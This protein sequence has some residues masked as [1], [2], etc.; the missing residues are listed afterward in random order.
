[1]FKTYENLFK[2]P[3]RHYKSP[4]ERGD[5][6]E[7]DTSPELN[8]EGIKQYQSLIGC[9]QWAISLGRF[10]IMVAVMTMS[11]FRVAP[12]KGHLERAKRI[13]GYLHRM[14]HSSIIFMTEEPDF[15]DLQ[16]LLPSWA[17]SVYGDVRERIPHDIPAPKGKAIWT[18]T[19]ADANLAHCFA[20]GR[21][22]MGVLHFLNKT[23][24]DWFSKKQSTVETSTYGSEFVAART[25]TEQIMDI[26]TTLRYFGVPIIDSIM[27]GDNKSVVDSS[28]IPT[29]VLHKR[30]TLLSYHRVREAIAAGIFRFY[31]LEGTENPADILSKHWGY[32]QVWKMLQLLLFNYDNVDQETKTT[33]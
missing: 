29:S 31:H 18:V 13:V 17:Q 16:T 24:W 1:V 26:R 11:S 10:D 20:T 32:Q 14:Q 4:L 23:P 33:S 28:S 5:H 22:V 9:L 27:F 30:H 7:L 19:Y 21:S 15:S 25:A 8:I 3:P 12:R 6:P 2:H